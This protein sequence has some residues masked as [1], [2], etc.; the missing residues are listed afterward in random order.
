MNKQLMALALVA[1]TALAAPAQATSTSI[2]TD[3]AWND[4][5][6]D[7]S[8]PPGYTNAWIDQADGSVMRF[9]F[10]IAAGSVGTLTIVDA[11]LAG[12]TFLVANNGT[13]LGQTSHVAANATMDGPYDGYDD[14]LA[15]P[16]YSRG[17][18]TLGA[19]SY[20][21]SGSL[22]QSVFEQGSTDGGLR[23]AVSAIPEPSSTALMF[24]G[25]AAVSLLARR[26]NSTPSI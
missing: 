7:A 22:L 1:T 20:S 14:A 11:G 4:F 16:A 12:D 13:L 23:V 15:D 21:I 9:T 18:F 3:G 5:A 17:V 19:G 26:R 2:A 8:Y 6:V 10:T 24:G 25:L